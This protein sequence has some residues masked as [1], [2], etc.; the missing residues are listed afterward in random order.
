MAIEDY[1]SRLAADVRSLED[2][3][4]R[5]RSNP[6]EALKGATQQFEAYFVQLMLKSMRETLGQDGL[7]DNDQT[8]FYTQ[9]MDQQV[10]Q[11]LGAKGSFGFA[12]LLEGQLGQS[13]PETSA[14]AGLN[15]LPQRPIAPAVERILREWRPSAAPGAA[16]AAGAAGAKPASAGAASSPDAPNPRDFVS[17]VWPH[18]V[19]A[20]ATTGLAPHLVVAHAALESGWGRSEPRMPDGTSSHNLFGIKAGSAW[21]GATVEAT[22]T[23]YVNGQP[24]SRVERFRAY[25]SYREAFVDYAKLLS[26]SPR[27]SG[28]LAAADGTDFAKSLQQSG[29]A[30]DPMYADKLVRI[31]NGKTLRDAL[32][33]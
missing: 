31:L 13:L 19:E 4:T 25:A 29:Y 3:K 2:L 6:R 28:V 12:R 32:F 23:E 1:G 22:T 7:F 20:S 24:E 9:M 11:Q 17:G 16:G 14:G 15:S 21:T 33:G 18:A 5:A 30:T 10:S 8:R 27:Y 26:T